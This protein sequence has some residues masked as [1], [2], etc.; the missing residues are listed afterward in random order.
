[1]IHLIDSVSTNESSAPITVPTHIRRAAPQRVVQIAITGTIA[2]AIEGRMTPDAQWL[3]LHTVTTSGATL[4]A[5]LP[6]MRVTTSGAEAGSEAS[7]WLDAEQ[8]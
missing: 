1:M 2:V 7:V 8:A 4:I 3:P 5:L 6:Q